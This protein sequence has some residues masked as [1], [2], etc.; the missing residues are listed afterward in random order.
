M[1]LQEHPLLS[2]SGRCLGS[3]AIAFSPCLSWK[4]LFQGSQGMPTMAFSS[5]P[6]RKRQLQGSTGRPKS[7][8]FRTILDASFDPSQFPFPPACRAKGYLSAPWECSQLPCP[9]ACRG[10]GNFG[11]PAGGP[12]PPLFGRFWMPASSGSVSFDPSSHGLGVRLRWDKRNQGPLALALR[13]MTWCALAMGQTP[14][15]SVSFGPSSHDLVCA[16]DGTNVTR[17]R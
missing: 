12:R 2:D 15:G 8:P 3:L 16:C 10:K 6:S 17:V 7:G 4:R 14:S 9:P 13:L 5:C 1:D 11:A